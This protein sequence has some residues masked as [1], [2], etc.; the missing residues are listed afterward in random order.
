MAYKSAANIEIGLSMTLSEQVEEGV[1]RI[2]EGLAAWQA[3]GVN[4]YSRSTLI[5]LAEKVAVIDQVDRGL[6]LFA[7]A[8]GPAYKHAENYCDAEYHRVKG[9]LRLL[10]GYA[11][12]EVESCF[13]QAIQ[14]ARQQKAKSLELRA[15]MDL[16]RLWLEQGKYSAARQRLAELYD[17]F[18]EGFDTPDLQ[19]A[20]QLL[21][22]LS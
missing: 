12:D 20:A 18:S 2:Q 4:L 6:A 10:Q 1:A 5:T 17:W 11:L 9:V 19:N 16:C 22:E 7:E 15:T 14:V 3:M 21:D 8:E 13:H